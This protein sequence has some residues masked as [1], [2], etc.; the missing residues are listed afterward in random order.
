MAVESERSRFGIGIAQGTT[1][2]LHRSADAT[3]NNTSA[4]GFSR[5]MKFRCTCGNII[6]DNGLCDHIKG[7]ILREQSFNAAY[8]QPADRIAEF[9]Q[10]VVAGKR[11]EWIEEFY[12][13]PY[14]EVSDSS[15]VFDI[16]DYARIRTKLDIYQCEACGRLFIEREPQQASGTMR[17]F[18]PE[19]AD[20][21]GTLS[22]DNAP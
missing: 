4:R 9:I 15:V 19:D 11:K 22:D 14:F 18:I 16:I 3:Q 8:E 1:Y 20:W 7:H 6:S 17:A 10:A 13:Q 5:V 2:Q 21:R 12:G